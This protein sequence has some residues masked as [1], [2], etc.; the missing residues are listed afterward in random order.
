[1][2]VIVVKTVYQ[3]Q[4][5]MVGQIS[6]RTIKFK[7]RKNNE[8]RAAT[9]AAMAAADLSGMTNP[10]TGRVWKASNKK[11]MPA[12]GKRNEVFDA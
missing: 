10:K 4:K 11:H 7:T 6:E 12:G 8:K 1:M 2:R 3:I 9:K 5:M